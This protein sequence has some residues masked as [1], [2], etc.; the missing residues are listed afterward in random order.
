MATGR[1]AFGSDINPVA[2]IFAKVK[3]DP[4]NDKQLVLERAQQVVD[5]VRRQ[6]EIP[7]ND[8]QR[9]AWNPEVLGFLNAARRILEWRTD[10]IDRTLMATIL[11]HLHA[12]AGEGLSNQMRQ[13]KAMAPEYSVEWWKKNN[14]FPPE[15]NV[16]DFLKSKL[17]WRYAKGI[18]KTRKKR[19]Q[20]ELGD[21]SQSIERMAISAKADLV[22]TS[23]PYCGVTNYRYDNWIRLW[24]L[25]EAPTPQGSS[26]ERYTNRVE[27]EQMLT[28][29][30]RACSI[31]AKRTATIY[32]RTDAREFTLD[33]TVAVLKSIWPSKS[34][35]L[36][37]DGFKKAT[38]TALFGDGSAKP[39]EVD[40]LLLPR[41][42]PIPD[43]FM[44][45]QD[46]KKFRQ[47]PA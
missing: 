35:L 27:Y 19:P 15:L 1:S 43:G 26:R 12:K 3:T 41:G 30:F 17:E 20:I 8:F 16:I 23:P 38:Q 11:V 10:K 31:K 22:F 5:S 24:M 47:N 6:D 32:V 28:D 42:K 44:S 39:G 34:M 45:L 2:W 46:F 14:S 25:G 4:C 36:M 18:V 37:H 33:T 7:A 9:W 13:S 40:I 21:A 29:V